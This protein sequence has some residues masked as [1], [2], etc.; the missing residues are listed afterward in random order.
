MNALE[1]GGFS[2]DDLAKHTRAGGG[3]TNLG[4]FLQYMNTGAGTIA[5][6]VGKYHGGIV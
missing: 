5:P 1:L 6:F 3:T 2:N 4:A